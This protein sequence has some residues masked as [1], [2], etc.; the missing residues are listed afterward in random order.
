[1]L[2]LRPEHP[3]MPRKHLKFNAFWILG[4]E[5]EDDD[6]CGGVVFIG[7]PNVFDQ[8]S[9]VLRVTLWRRNN[10]R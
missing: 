4:T 2:G 3:G 5:P 7:Q 9:V 1:M 10:T 6:A 8:R